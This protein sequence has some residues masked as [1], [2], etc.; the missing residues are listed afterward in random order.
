M[1][2][3]EF[4]ERRYRQIV[5]EPIRNWNEMPVRKLNVWLKDVATL[6]GEYTSR[7]K[8]QNFANWPLQA[9]RPGAD[10]P[11][12]RQVDATSKAMIRHARLL[13][14]ALQS[15]RVAA[16]FK[17]SIPP[18]RLIEQEKAPPTGIGHRTTRRTTNEVDR[19]SVMIAQIESITQPF[20]RDLVDPADYMR[21]QSGWLRREPLPEHVTDGEFV[22]SLNPELHAI[23]DFVTRCLFR[24]V[25][26]L[27]KILEEADRAV[28]S[29][30]P[31]LGR[32]VPKCV[33]E[34]AADTAQLRETIRQLHVVCWPDGLATIRDSCI[35]LTQAYAAF[36]P[37]PVTGWLGLADDVM[38]T[39]R[40]VLSH[41]F[42]HTRNFELTERVAT[43][44]GDLRRLYANEPSNQ[45][46]LEEAISRGG[47]VLTTSPKAAY[48]A[49]KH[50]EVEWA[51]HVR[52]WELFHLL[53]RKGYRGADVQEKDVFENGG[54][55]AAMSTLYSR[56]NQL[57]PAA[58]RKQI[59]PGTQPR[60]YRLKLD[61]SR[62]FIVPP[63]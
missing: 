51:Q 46:V 63:A 28:L 47:L 9:F 25:E 37:A 2:R 36:H 44:L 41:R 5:P 40:A 52:P 56:L 4:A 19:L 16:A 20:W 8:F 60:S 38:T 49:G 10:T 50:L 32:V 57:L 62:I 1:D 42:T 29:C 34:L 15:R 48:W 21:P 59:E 18:L 55:P 3:I 7:P 58:L 33:S 53:A 39:G 23:G 54:S 43:A 31:S 35:I 13:H 30:V 17:A 24:R 26:V 22:V 11:A 6:V 12:R 45:S 14:A 61:P 27:V